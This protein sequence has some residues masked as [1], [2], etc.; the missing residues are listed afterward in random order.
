[1]GSHERTENVPRAHSTAPAAPLAIAAL[2]G[3]MGF[4]AVARAQQPDPK[5]G[6]RAS[7]SQTTDK[8]DGSKSGDD[9]SLLE[10]SSEPEPTPFDRVFADDWFATARP[11]FEIHGYYR[12]RS[13]LFAH[14]DLGRRDE[15]SRALWPRPASDAYVDTSGTSH[16]VNLCG[17]DPMNP[18]AC[19]SFTQGGANT[20]LRIEPTLTVSDNIRAV[21][22]IDLFDNLVLGS[23]PEGYTSRPSG[24]GGYEVQQSGGYTPIGAFAATQWAPSGGTSSLSDSIVVKR[25]YGEYV[26]PIGTFR[27]GRMP[28]QWGLGMMYNS[29]DGYDQDRGST[30]DRIMIKSGIPGWE[31]Y[32]AGMWDFADEGVTGGPF[33]GCQESSG[34]G[35]CASTEL[36]AKRYDLIQSDDMYQWGLQVY[37]KR[38][39]G[40]EKLDLAQGKVVVNGGAYGIYRNQA[41][42]SVAPLGASSREVTDTLVRR[43]YEAFVPDAWAE[44]KW[45][46]LYIGV[47]A[48]LV[49]GS[50]DNTNV[51]TGSNNF[52][53][54][55][56]PGDKADGWNLR[57]FGF[58]FESQ[59]R[60]VEDRLRVD[61]GFGFA[62]GDSDVEGING[63][64]S[65]TSD[66]ALGGLDSQLTKNRTF[67]SFRFHPDYQ[68]DQILFRR[69]MTRVQSAYYFRPGFA[70]DVMRK[71]DG[72]RAGGGLNLVWS[73]ASEPV[74]AP[75][76]APDLGVELDA[77]IYYQG[78]GGTFDAQGNPKTGFY[79]QLDYA[80]LFPL[81]G[82]GYLPG[83]RAALG[84]EAT[85]LS[86][87]HMLRLYM[88]IMF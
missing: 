86:V 84:E 62:S 46:K 76:N 68:I 31:L 60:A 67:S 74:Q 14:F 59:W 70:Y 7:E 53:N 61:F 21:A 80:V 79:G 81:D 56:V 73:R 26:S 50:I 18:E 3:L 11:T 57:Q 24:S 19:S 66:E 83:E 5:A 64:G 49:W 10:K 37:R 87:A 85:S 47:E 43:G 65:G 40:L 12:V 52:D 69:I 35:S 30:V 17:D 38:D 16:T 54:P 36:Q 9:K 44:L 2:L 33:Y 58:A 72:Q 28:N 25:A 27:F 1:M 32:F 22:Q 20:R 6:P 4:P 63:L 15:P 8:K 29:G 77:K 42:E 45:K 75:G 51:R 34:S 55:D 78:L 13:E 39:P 48:A 71:G 23:T 82:L 41:L 88:G